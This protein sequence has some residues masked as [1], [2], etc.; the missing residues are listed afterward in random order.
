MLDVNKFENR[1]VKFKRIAEGGAV[2]ESKAEIRRMVYD[3]SSAHPRS[4][5][6]RFVGP[7]LNAIMTLNYD[8]DKSCFRGGLG[9]DIIESDFDI[10]EFIKTVQLGNADVVVK[11]P[12]RNRSKLG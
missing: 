9:P 4:L 3:K 8:V 1:I 10:S 12:K 7:P 2:S 11:S 6:A 5:T